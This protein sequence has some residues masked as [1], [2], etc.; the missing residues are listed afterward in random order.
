MFR[1]LLLGFLLAFD[2]AAAVYE[3]GPGKALG[4]VNDVPWEALV[5]GDEVRIHWRA[6]PYREKFV[7]CRQGTAQKPIKVT[8]VPGHEGRLPVIDGRDATTRK[9]LNFW[10]EERAVIKIGGANRPADTTP[11]H[12]IISNLEIRSARQPYSF[13]GRKGR[14]SYRK[15]AASIYIEKGHHITIINCRLRDSG[16]GIITAPATTD[17]TV[18][19]CH[20]F[21]NGVAKSLYEHNAYI[22]A[23]RVTFEYNRFGPL[24]S[25]CLGNNFKDRSAGLRFRCNWV[26]GGNRCLD[27]VDSGD[28][29]IS[30]DR[31]YAGAAVWGNVFIK[32]QRASNNQV[33]HF[34]G[35]SGRLDQYRR[36]ILWFH[37][38]SVISLRQGNTVLFRNAA[39][40][41]T[42]DCMNNIV[43]TALPD[44]RLNVRSGDDKG[45]FKVM[46][47]WLSRGW[48]ESPGRSSQLAYPANL[49]TDDPGFVSLPDGNLRLNQRSVCRSFGMRVKL[50][51]WFGGG[52]LTSQ[53]EPHQR[54][55]LRPDFS[56]NGPHALG[57]FGAPR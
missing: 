30:G 44:G 45:A 2:L 37:N 41:A 52:Y 36:G 49:S 19:G 46:R 24:R 13:S 18:S 50:D 27:L 57:A 1:G 34:G 29:R 42:I 6:E 43:H 17:L 5:P 14:T 11:A 35:D 33:V 7:L 12:L 23:L 53:Y 8:G 9:Q 40:G 26:E 20:I 32:T 39:P 55:A 28:R 38:N 56:F 22:S 21:D 4:A 16:N 54:H 48:R 51:G 3:V 15:N 10:G 47:N 25:G 31:L